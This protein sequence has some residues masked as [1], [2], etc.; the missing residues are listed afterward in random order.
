MILHAAKDDDTVAGR[1][2]LVTEELEAVAD[3]ERGDLA[4][5]QPLARLR[6]RQLRLANANR[7]RAPFGLAGLD[8]ELTEEV[9][10]S[11]ASSPVCPLV[12]GGLQQG[13]ED[14]RGRDLQGGQ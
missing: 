10:L 8:Q 1:L 12:S 11:R 3:A 13:F 5:D 14:F 4:L 2:D 9:G 7:K 6:Q